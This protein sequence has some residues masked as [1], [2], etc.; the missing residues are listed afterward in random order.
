MERAKNVDIQLPRFVHICTMTGKE[1]WVETLFALDEVGD[2]W[3]YAN[4]DEGWHP[5]GMGR[6]YGGHGELWPPEPDTHVDYPPKAR[7]DK[8]F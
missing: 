5:L 1:E 3:F 7:T 8:V 2:V 6:T 4:T